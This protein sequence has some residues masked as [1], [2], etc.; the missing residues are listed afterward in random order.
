MTMPAT[1]LASTD[2]AQPAQAGTHWALLDLVRFSAA[3]LVL[4]GHA[5]GLL[6][7]GIADVEH[8]TLAIKAL[9]F[10]S[11]LQHEG[12]V[13]FFVVSGFL[14]GGSAWR[15]I[16]D[17]RFRYRSYLINRFARIYLV[18]LPA[19]LLVLVL[20][21]LGKSGF[22]D[23]RFYGMRPLFPAGVF[24]EWT[25]SQVPCHLLTLQGIVCMPW[26]ADPPLWSL[27]YEWVF[28]LIAPL[29]L[30]PALVAKRRS[31]RDLAVP[32]ALV[33]LLTW[34][35]S[36]WL[37]WFALWMLGAVA[38]RAF[39]LRPASAAAALAGMA[40]VAAGLVI[41]RLK[42][43]PVTATDVMVAGGLALAIANRGLMK[44]GRGLAPIRRGAGF[45]YSLYLIHLPVCLMVG[46]LYQ[47][48]LGWPA[49][50]VQPDAHGLLG[51]AGMIAAAVAAAW[52]FA[53]ATEDH[54][55]AV[56]RWLD[57]VLPGR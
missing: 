1:R 4:F 36:E 10:L 17:G 54:T 11:G 18:Y 25:W 57:R 39:A 56:R 8:P 21:Q 37:F 51:M 50:L 42:L 44:L 55:S 24:D 45:S 15:L 43:V 23:T 32:V 40:L 31:A 12:V 14:V 53:L 47:R 30:F 6:L 41:S 35:N 29:V 34:W 46:A 5:R 9:Y 48:W 19:L 49:G 52:L 20:S 13:M 28:Y 38:A 33:L 16:G 7:V 3:L 26:G 22:P 27:G 2:P